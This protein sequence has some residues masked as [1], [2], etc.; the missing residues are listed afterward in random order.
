MSSMARPR[1]IA[2][3]LNRLRGYIVPTGL[4]DTELNARLLEIEV[5]WAA[6]LS[7]AAAFNSAYALRLGATNAQIGLLSSIPALITLV[8]TIPAGQFLNRRA[9]RMPWVIWSL[10][11]A[12][13]GYL[14]VALIPFLG[15]PH[16]GTLVVWTLIALA[17]PAALFGVGWN[18]MLA[19]VVPEAQR[20]RLFAVRNILLAIV[21]SGGTFIAGRWLNMAH[22]P[23]S[24]Q[25][26]Y[27]V[28]FAGSVL[29]T[30]YIMLMR[31]P[32]SPVA[33]AT[34]ASLSPRALWMGARDAFRQQPD[35]PRIV[36]NTLAHGVG[37]W[38]VGPVYVLY[39]VRQ[40]RASDGWIGTNAMVANLTP[41]IGYYFWQRVIARRGENWVLRL[42]ISLIGLYPMLVGLTP[43]LTIILLWTGLQGL[44]APGINLGH[45]PLLLKICP[46]ESGPLYIG[47]YTTIMNIGAFVMPLVGVALAEYVGYAPVLIAGGVMCLLGSSLFRW[48]PLQTPDSLAVRAA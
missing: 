30:I 3:W 32:D 10:A 20:A 34:T 29:S 48:R 28:G 37:L 11:L 24:Y 42:T 14:A 47:I 43:N 4:N 26:V 16:P 8:I 19:D 46:A 41:I 38:M 13:L 9:R 18:S 5:F 21:V 7:A 6:F 33:A 1:H 23:F 44:I 22:P 27:L 36:V 12:R 40:L 45:F 31:V 2:A 17:A 15:L 25:V 39:Y 35:F